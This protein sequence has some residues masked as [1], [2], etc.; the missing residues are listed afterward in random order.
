MGGSRVVHHLASD[1]FFPTP[2][3][4]NENMENEVNVL[5][6]NSVDRSQKRL[7]VLF[8]NLGGPEKLKVRNS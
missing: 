4:S 2:V 7:G 5:F 1:T 8:L 3:N 6:N